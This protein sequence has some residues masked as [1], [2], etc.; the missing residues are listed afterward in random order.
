[1]SPVMLHRHI[2]QLSGWNIHLEQGFTDPTNHKVLH[3][4]CRDNCNNCCSCC[5]ITINLLH[6]LKTLL[7]R[8]TSYTTLEQCLLWA[9]FSLANYGFMRISYLCQTPF[10]CQVFIG[11]STHP[12]FR[13]HDVSQK[14]IFSKGII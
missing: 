3:M 12:Q 9:A 4:V 1:M 11:L 5:L 8:S 6:I 14:Q 2:W 10:F 7:S 13:L